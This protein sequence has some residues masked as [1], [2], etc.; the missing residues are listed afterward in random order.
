MAIDDGLHLSFVRAGPRDDNNPCR[1]TAHFS[2]FC[3]RIVVVF[4]VRVGMHG[5]R[6]K[7]T[8]KGNADELAGRLA[9]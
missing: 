3:S 5:N 2:D 7:A 9:S 6:W 1:C 4:S 8:G